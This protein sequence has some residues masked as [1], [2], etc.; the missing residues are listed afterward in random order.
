MSQRVPVLTLGPGGVTVDNAAEGSRQLR[1][2]GLLPAIGVGGVVYIITGMV[3]FGTIAL[4]GIGAGVGYG[5][6]NWLCE[7]YDRTK[8]SPVG[9]RG[10]SGASSG[11]DLPESYRNSLAQW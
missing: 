10:V 6:G 8:M 7:H 11:A 1:S 2:K 4:V 5:I 3:S 9:G